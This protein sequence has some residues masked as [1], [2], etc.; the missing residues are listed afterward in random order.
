MGATVLKVLILLNF[1]LSSRAQVSNSTFFREGTKVEQKCLCDL[2]RHQFEE[3]CSHCDCCRNDS[4]KHTHAGEFYNT[5]DDNLTD[6]RGM[7]SS[8]NYYETHWYKNQ[9][10]TKNATSKLGNISFFGDDQDAVNYLFGK[11]KASCTVLK[12]TPKL[13]INTT[14]APYNYLEMHFQPEKENKLKRRITGD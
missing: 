10:R 12:L 5:Y 11:N 14:E 4:D 1:L 8:T 6:F 7:P 13:L 3:Q 2:C 9:T